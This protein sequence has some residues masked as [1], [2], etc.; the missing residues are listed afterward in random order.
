VN[1]PP[2]EAI[3]QRIRSIVSA[4]GG[5]ADLDVEV[6]SGI[7]RLRGHADSLAVGEQATALA[8]RVEGVVLVKNDLQVAPHVR[9][10][11]TPVWSRLKRYLGAALGFLPVLAVALAAFTAFALLGGAVGRWQRPFERLG[12]SPLGAR[13][14]RVL[15]RV[16]LITTG[17]VLALE[18]LG[19]VTFVGTVVGALGLVGVV[20]G[21]AFRDVVSNHLPGVMLGLSPP[22]HPGD[23]VRIGDDEGRVVRVTSRETI[24][25]ANDGQQLRLPNV[26]LLQK[27]I[28]NLARHRER[29]LQLSV[30]IALSAD[31][32]KVRDVGLETLLAVP[33]VLREPRPSMRVLEIGSDHVRVAFFAWIDQRTSNFLELESRARQAVKEGLQAADVPFPVTEIAVHHADADST[34]APD[35]DSDGSPDDALLDAHLRDELATSGERDLLHEGRSRRT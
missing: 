16:T 12:L 23:R 27:P 15:L 2:D 32:R 18:I 7:V 33:G 28:V 25:V 31:L 4:L 13:G 9:G 30:D 14:L 19:W 29:R 11:L 3:A 22:F 24:L 26:L 17:M 8:E 10:R 34:R 1:P 20:V 6:R 5:T 21:I 35:E